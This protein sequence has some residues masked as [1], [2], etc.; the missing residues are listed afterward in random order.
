[1]TTSSPINPYEPPRE[2]ALPHGFSDRE[3]VE[4]A[5]LRRRVSDLERQVGRS[6][7]VHGNLFQKVLAVWGY[8]LLG[9]V[10][11]VSAVLSIMLIIRLLTRVWPNPQ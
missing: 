1:M 6:W 10:M 3:A 4:V 9:Y 2:P 5:E 8:L 7:L 11:V